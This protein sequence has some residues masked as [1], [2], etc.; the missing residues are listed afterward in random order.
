I[1]SCGNKPET[2]NTG[3]LKFELD[4]LMVD[5]GGEI[6][7]LNGMDFALSPDRRYFYNFNKYDHSLE[8]IDLEELRLV[9]KLPFEVEGPNGTGKYVYYLNM[10]DENHIQLSDDRTSGQ[11]HVNGTRLVSRNL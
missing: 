10:L 7:D 8:K 9:E 1:F 11:F 3:I 5:A 4:T 2:S 6:L